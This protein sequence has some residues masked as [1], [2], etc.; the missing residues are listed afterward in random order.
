[1]DL[2]NTLIITMEEF[3]VLATTTIMVVKTT[4]P[5]VGGITIMVARIVAAV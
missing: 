3:W 1:M 4:Q 5:E 2:T